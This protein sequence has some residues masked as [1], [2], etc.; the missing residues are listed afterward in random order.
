MANSISQYDDIIQTSDI[1]E[2][3]EELESEREAFTSVI[4]DEDSSPDEVATATAELAAWDTDNGEELK[5]LE[6]LLSDI[7]GM[8]GDEQWR[9][10][11]Y[12]QCLIRYSH[13]EQYM[14]ETIADCYS[15]PEL[16]SFMTITLDYV[17]LQQDYSTVEFMGVEYL[18]R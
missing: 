16:P 17:A 5:S 13:F 4:E 2:R 18:C 11:W 8:G 14:D 3:F 6:S 12:P 15:L 7:Q 9:G 10:D 1:T